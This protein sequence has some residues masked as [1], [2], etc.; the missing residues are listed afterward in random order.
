[1]PSI[2]PESA[3]EG[4]SSFAEEIVPLNLR[5]ARLVG[6]VA[7]IDLALQAGLG[8]MRG[9]H[10]LAA[11]AASGAALMLAFAAAAHRANRVE[12]GDFVRKA[13]P[14]GLVLSILL[15]AQALAV[16]GAPPTDLVSGYAI[17]LIGV[18]ALFKLTPR[19]FILI[20]FGSFLPMV[21]WVA[22]RGTPVDTM[23]QNIG[24]AIYA[25]AAAI[26]IRTLL[27]RARHRDYRL[28]TIIAAQNRALNKANL[29]LAQRNHDIRETM[30]IAAHD[31]RSPLAGLYNLLRLAA[32]K[33]AM[34]PET[35]RS[36]HEEGSRSIG[37]VLELL[38]K[39]L[40]AHEADQRSPPPLATHELV[41]LARAAIDRI[42]LA[43]MA[44]G[45]TVEL[46]GDESPL[47][48]RTDQETI[49][50]ILDNLL[51]N[52]VR[53]SPVGGVVYVMCRRGDLTATIEVLDEG[54]GVP[55]SDQKRIFD[56]FQRGSLLP[57]NGAAG[58]GLGLYIAREA[59]SSISAQL[60]YRRD[61]SGKSI[62]RLT[63]PLL[64]D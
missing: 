39:L 29:E 9:N 10:A 18:A 19:R 50:R 35:L 5:R 37:S 54:P 25:L 6:V 57:P 47:P 60:D 34:R 22:V 56:K 3:I 48:I 8:A 17:V 61:G 59:A 13:I 23:L 28:R 62:F 30:A 4:V 49:G 26:M 45:V 2:R 27:Y 20:A 40:E 53:Y 44:G 16:V 1:M 58:A 55:P 46:I 7:A 21:V 63:V 52:A 31:L 32:D 12:A 41:S 42:A 43:A 51:S 15:L 64:A 11:L 24:T 14:L 33:P 38:N 36:L